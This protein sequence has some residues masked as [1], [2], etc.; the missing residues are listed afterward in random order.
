MSLQIIADLGVPIILMHMQGSPGTMQKNPVYADAPSEIR[1]YLSQRAN[2]CE[3][4]GIKASKIAIDPG[5]G[6]GKTLNHNLEIAKMVL[7]ALHLL[8]Y[9]PF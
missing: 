4:A 1:G 6:F 2:E 7:P 5:I 8:Y 3:R 9:K